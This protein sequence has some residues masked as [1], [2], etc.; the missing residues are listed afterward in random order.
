MWLPEKNHRFQN[1]GNKMVNTVKTSKR[2]V[3]I[4]K[5]RNHLDMTG[6]SAKLSAGPKL[7]NHGPTLLRAVK[8]ALMASMNSIPSTVRMKQL[9]TM[10]VR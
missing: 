6:T 4:R 3:I 9:A 5:Q 7:P 10:R 2:P 1:P 8:V